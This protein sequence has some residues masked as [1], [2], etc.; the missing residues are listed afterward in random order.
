MWLDIPGLEGWVKPQCAGTTLRCLLTHPWLCGV[1]T[2]P[3]NVF[4]CQRNAGIFPQGHS[5]WLFI[6]FFFLSFHLTISFSAIYVSSSFP[7][8]ETFDFR[9]KSKDICWNF[10]LFLSL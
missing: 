9:R 5:L 3:Q 1:N 6:E 8:S 10:L 2:N 4:C 7:V